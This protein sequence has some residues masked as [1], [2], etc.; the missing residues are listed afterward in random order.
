MDQTKVAIVS[1][2]ALATVVIA[3]LGY[4]F[5]ANHWED[6]KTLA[7]LT[8]VLGGTFSLAV[9]GLKLKSGK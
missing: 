7:I 8:I 4:M 1:V 9:G 3:G 2:I 5:I 6:I